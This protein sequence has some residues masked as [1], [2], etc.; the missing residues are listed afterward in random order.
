[1]NPSLC[2]IQT[3][4]EAIIPVEKIELLPDHSEIGS[5]DHQMFSCMGAMECFGT[6]LVVIQASS[7]RDHIP[8]QKRSTISFRICFLRHRKVLHYYA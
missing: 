6:I 3:L 7:I 8:S 5:L 2:F 1:M 4:D